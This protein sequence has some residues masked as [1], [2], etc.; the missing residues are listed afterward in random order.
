MVVD[1]LIFN[2]YSYSNSANLEGQAIKEW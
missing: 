1:D 2:L